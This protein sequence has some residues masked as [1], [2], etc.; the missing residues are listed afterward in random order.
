MLFRSVRKS[1]DQ[2]CA[3]LAEDRGEEL[4]VQKVADVAPGHFAGGGRGAVESLG[5]GKKRV[6]QRGTKD[7]GGQLEKTG[8]GDEEDPQIEEFLGVA[9]F[10][11]KKEEQAPRDQ[12]DREEVGAQAE[13][14]K[15]DTAE[16]GAGRSDEIGFGL[17]GRLG[18]EGEILGVEG[19]EG[20]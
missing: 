19:E 13:E 14:E 20:E 2:D 15:K 18:I 7:G 12:H 11:G 6:G 8:P 16:V 1:E 5:P 3:D 17:L 9:D 10:L 4:V